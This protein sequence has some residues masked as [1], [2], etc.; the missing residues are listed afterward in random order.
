MESVIKLIKKL[1]RRAST[2]FSS[3]KKKFSKRVN[4][5]SILEHVIVL[6]LYTL[7][8]IIA[9]HK[10]FILGIDKV[11]IGDGG[12][13]YQH[14]WNFW[15]VRKAII[16][17]KDIFYTDYLFYPHGT[18]LYFHTLN[19][20]WSFLSIPFQH[21]LDRVAIYNLFLITTCVLNMIS[22]YFL[23][24]ILL[25]D[26]KISFIGGFS[27]GFSTY[28]WGKAL[29]QL[30]LASIFIFPLFLISYIKFINSTSLRQMTIWGFIIS[31]NFLLSLLVHY[32]YFIIM[33]LLAVFL[34]MFD[35]MKI[36]KNLRLIS[37]SILVFLFSLLLISPFLLRFGKIDYRDA[38]IPLDNVASVKLEDYFK[39]SPF[40]I[41]GLETNHIFY[42][43]PEYSSLANVTS[44]GFTQLFIIICSIIL[45]TIGKISLS[46]NFW[47]FSFLL[48]C[49]FILS[50]GPIINIPFF[51]LRL[52]SPMYEFLYFYFPFFNTIGKV[53]KVN[54]LV[55][56]LFN[57]IFCHSLYEISKKV[58][59]ARRNIIF[60][61]LT[62]FF[63][64]IENFPIYYYF[65]SIPEIPH[66]LKEKDIIIFE[67]PPLEN[68]RGMYYQTIHENRLIG[69]YISRY[70]S[71]ALTTMKSIEDYVKNSYRGELK[72]ILRNLNL[73]YI[74]LYKD[75][76]TQDPKY[77][78]ILE[79]VK[80]LEIYSSP[81]H[82]VYV[83]SLE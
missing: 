51:N 4:V 83:V 29:G 41:I 14:V 22:F 36:I 19:L 17:G 18:H 6:E 21:F 37:I 48:I 59:G 63:V 5:D 15:W 46:K 11:L 3:L 8:T 16:E 78:K 27:F 52:P 82:S 75:Y 32:H 31:L 54:V 66:L 30:D 2:T 26:K 53:P 58:N 39:P 71:T 81:H 43:W 50:L 28:F 74:I 68:F 56:F 42:P 47:K 1:L 60:V 34:F 7:L 49:F 45:H 67:I 24:N 70:P 23:I 73:K 65:Y 62:F 64:L 13:A 57:I 44:L 12:D 79:A 76:V 10:V 80:P 38:I 9:F 61:A 55:M 20:L 25:K 69:G 33:I 72:E 77:L 35:V 40:S